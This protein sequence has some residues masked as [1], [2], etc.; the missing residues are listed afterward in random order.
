MKEQDL[1]CIIKLLKKTRTLF[2]VDSAILAVGFLQHLKRKEEERGKKRDWGLSLGLTVHQ[3][4]GSVW[5]THLESLVDGHGQLMWVAAETE[6]VA[7]DDA[8]LDI[9]F[10]KGH[11]GPHVSAKGADVQK[12]SAEDGRLVG[13]S[14][15][16]LT[17]LGS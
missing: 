15:H 8:D 14:W 1:S 5:R 17:N 2:F 9:V 13:A 11:L 10:E 3:R 4:S 12:K 16:W 6:G 7:C